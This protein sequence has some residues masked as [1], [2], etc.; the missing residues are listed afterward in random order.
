MII[1]GPQ[2]DIVDIALAF[3]VLGVI[4]IAVVVDVAAAIGWLR[5]RP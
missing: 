4:G 1:A 5:R 2:V 3:I